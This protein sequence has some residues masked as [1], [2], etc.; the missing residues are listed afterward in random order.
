MGNAKAT[1]RGLNPKGMPLLG[2][3]AFVDGC[4]AVGWHYRAK[5]LHRWLNSSPECGRYAAPY[6]SIYDLAWLGLP[7]EAFEEEVVWEPSDKFFRAPL[8]GFA[9]ES[10]Q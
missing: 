7:L 5:S 1:W 2:V 3:D 6:V 8:V 4:R 9:D 10:L